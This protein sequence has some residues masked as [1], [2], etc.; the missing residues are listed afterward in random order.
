MVPATFLSAMGLGA[1]LGVAGIGLPF[2]ELGIALSVVTMGLVVAA[3]RPWPVGL[4]MAMVGVFALFHGR[5]HGAEMPRDLSGVGYGLGFVLAT[6]LLHVAGI[7]LAAMS[8]SP[9]GRLTRATGVA[10]CMAGLISVVAAGLE[11]QLP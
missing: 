9:I 7:T 8:R 1:G 11:G 2:F 4:A 6:A 5:A 3:G 10:I